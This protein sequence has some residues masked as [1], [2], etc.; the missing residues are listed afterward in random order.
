MQPVAPRNQQWRHRCLKAAG[1]DRVASVPHRP[2][3]ASAFGHKVLRRHLVERLVRERQRIELIRL[4]LIPR[5]IRIPA[6]VRG[7]LRWF[8]AK[9]GPA[10]VGTTFQPFALP[11]LARP[12]R[13]PPS[14]GCVCGQVCCAN[15]PPT[16]GTVGPTFG[17][18]RSRP[19][20]LPLPVWPGAIDPLGFNPKPGGS[21]VGSAQSQGQ[22]G[23]ESPPGL[24]L[25]LEDETTQSAYPPVD[26]SEARRVART[27]R[28]RR[29]KL[30]QRSTP[31]DRD[32][33]QGDCPPDRRECTSG[34][35][36]KPGGPT[37][38]RTCS[39]GVFGSG[40]YPKSHQGLGCDC[41]TAGVSGGLQ[42]AR[43][44]VSLPLPDVAPYASGVRPKPLCWKTPEARRRSGSSCASKLGQ[45]EKVSTRKLPM[46][47]I[48]GKRG[49]NA[50][51]SM[52]A[53]YIGARKQESQT[54]I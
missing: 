34:A 29:V 48:P 31:A 9:P 6:I 13:L 14:G 18:S 40:S 2:G 35:T 16:K 49:A 33:A 53:P 47:S 23:P 24:H 50:L 52:P 12:P 10:E 20:A 51:R 19:N 39:Q 26:P 3:M 15:G 21:S 38:G 30:A 11:W 5:A 37:G 45:G 36:W 4:G 46:A 44:T 54:T 42:F 27:V 17:S 32:R 43:P 28:R 22:R 1:K 25:A 8:G 7:L 41:K